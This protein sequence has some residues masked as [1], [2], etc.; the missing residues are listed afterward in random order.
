MKHWTEIYPEGIAFGVTCSCGWTEMAA[1]R[2]TAVDMS[3][4]HKDYPELPPEL[5]P[6]PSEIASQ[7]Q[8]ASKWYWVAEHPHWQ[9][10]AVPECPEDE[11]SRLEWV[12]LVA[13]LGHSND[14][15]QF[16]PWA[17]AA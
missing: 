11:N 2:A 9:K 17:D 14:D 7:A 12:A 1:S 16:D 6:T 15:T 8:E 4:Q 13:R 10:D 5:M 3:K